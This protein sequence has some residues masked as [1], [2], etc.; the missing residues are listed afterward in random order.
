MLELSEH[1]EIKTADK[2]REHMIDL[3]KMGYRIAM[4][5]L[6]AGHNGLAAFAKIGPDIVKIDIQ[7]IRGAEKERTKLR[8]IGSL[9]EI[10]RDLNIRCIA[11]GV[12]TRSNCSALIE[13]GCDLYQG[14]LFG[15]PDRVLRPFVPLPE[16]K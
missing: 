6:G 11:E 9:I 3:R 16:E 2:V 14:Y 10:C 12:E 1:M 8:L 7:L 13:T 5:D 4:D 15:K